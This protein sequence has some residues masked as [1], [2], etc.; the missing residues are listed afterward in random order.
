MP[1]LEPAD[2]EPCGVQQWSLVEQPPEMKRPQALGSHR[3][4]ARWRFAR[5]YRRRSVDR[6]QD[7]PAGAVDQCESGFITTQDLPLREIRFAETRRHQFST[8]AER[9]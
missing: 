4:F 1:R 7:A 6:C 3:A 8:A 5:R 2:R 9:F